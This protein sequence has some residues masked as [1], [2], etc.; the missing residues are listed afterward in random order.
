MAEVTVALTVRSL[1]FRGADGSAI[2][3]GYDASGAKIKVVATARSLPRPPLAGETWRIMGVFREHARYGRQLHAIKG[4]Y[5][6]PRGRLL[7]HYLASNPVFAGIGERR[8]HDLYAAFGDRLTA[9]LDAADSETLASVIPA[10]IAKGLVQG[11]ATKREEAALVA[12][13]DAQGFDVRLANQLRRV[14]GGQAQAM[15]EANPYYML[16]F[17]SWDVTDAA[18]LKLGVALED[19]RR[20]LGAVE[21]AL[22]LRLQDA[23]TLTSADRLR[24]KLR[25]WLPHH[26]MDKAIAL[27]L[28]EGAIVGDASAGY[29]PIGAAALEA[30]I[31][32][33]IRSMLAG[34]TP[35]QGSLFPTE[36]NAAW[37]ATVIAENE[38]AQGFLL[39]AQQR[40]AVLMATTQPFSVL[41]GGAG[42]GKTTILR[43]VIDIARR[44][45]LK[46][47]QMAL[48]GRAAKRMTAATGHE[49][50]TIARFLQKAKA[51]KL[52]VTPDTLVI[53]DEASMLDL[54]ST[55]RILRQLPEGARVLLVGD[56]AQLPPIGFGLVFHTLAASAA[57]PRVELTEVHRQAA[58]TGIPGIAADIRV[59]HVP[60][61][62]PYAGLQ[63]GVTF[64]ECAPAEI[65]DVLLRL[66]RDWAG[67]DWQI[68]AA[69]NRG[70]VGIDGI[71]A[72][73]HGEGEGY[74]AGEPVI[75]LINDYDRGLMNGTLGRVLGVVEGSKPGLR[76]AFE[77][78]EHVLEDF[79]V[80]DRLELAYAISTHKAQGSQFK[81]VAVV[82]VPSRI[83]DHALVYT[84]L[85]RGV[86][87]VVF[88]GS[89]T[90]FD[91][92]VREPASASRRAIGFDIKKI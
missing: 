86:E 35:T 58:Q 59:H 22:Y 92:A 18:A 29:Q 55:F 63:P 83:L 61:L 87:Q 20:L 10:D 7:V 70:P 73:F 75:H 2:F 53:L 69:V 60:A 30:R 85:T 57:I 90:V 40:A 4:T 13:L 1:T 34:E 56:P 19:D 39:N 74:R 67:E 44:L 71:N 91:K 41:T 49:A 51:G 80:P 47:I 31:A 11:W 78:V 89:R 62:A 26:L 9:L 12:W 66:S 81:R 32:E 77:G 38:R 72:L 21:A 42:V 76:I 37:L 52:K 65:P 6:L 46:V 36:V 43:V 5:A 45:E 82:V 16:A 8:A 68:L 15:L 27:A 17:A 84:A 64:L 48:A 3:A 88:V 28:A 25:A 23:H 54:P 24:Q 33:R 79:E 50:L 14:W